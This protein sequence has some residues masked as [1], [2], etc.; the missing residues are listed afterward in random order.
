MS[1]SLEI[2][3]LQNRFY[4]D[5]YCLSSFHVVGEGGLFRVGKKTRFVV[6][7]QEKEEDVVHMY[8]RT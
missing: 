8:P 1:C 5:G 3:D 7:K 6:R 4:G 2:A